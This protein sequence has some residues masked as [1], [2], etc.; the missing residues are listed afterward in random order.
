M[1]ASINRLNHLANKEIVLIRC[2]LNRFPWNV[3]RPIISSLGLSSGHGKEKTID[4]ILTA[5]DDLK[6]S[7]PQKF[8]RT[9]DKI[10]DLLFS[11]FLYGDKALYSISVDD[12][13]L[14]IIKINIEKEW[15]GKKQKNKIS[16]VLIDESSLSKTQKNELELLHY[17]NN[18][19]QSLILFSSVRDQLI[20]ETLPPSTVPGFKDYDEIIAKKKIKKQCFDSCMIDFVSKKINIM[21]DL[22]GGISA[23]DSLFP[24]SV[25][26]R[27]FSD[28]LGR[29]LDYSEKDFFSLIEPICEQ[30]LAPY[31]SLDYRVFDLS[32]HTREG[33]SHKEKKSDS[34]KDLRD[35]IFNVAGIKASGKIGLYRIGIR[36]ERSN[37]D[38]QLYDNLELLIPGTLRRYLS[39]GKT[40]PVT[41]AI[42]NNCITRSDFETLTKFIL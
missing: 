6:S 10:N 25:V 31:N 4:K 15:L 13:D 36:I 32:F 17:S 26:L 35:D 1:N 7:K 20:R 41:Y 12:A 21:I 30:T 9:I 11:Q 16:D 42:I 33:T 40:S 29:N 19:T 3:V 34:S 38:L 14:K 24:K 39:G 8:A 27:K 2:L 37:P 5:M 22:S 23:S 28:Y 18:K